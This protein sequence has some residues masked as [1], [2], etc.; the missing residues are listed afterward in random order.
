MA[1]SI[2]ALYLDVTLGQPQ[3]P[4]V[5]GFHPVLDPWQREGGRA[6][7]TWLVSELWR[8]LRSWEHLWAWPSLLMSP[9]VASPDSGALPASS[10]HFEQFETWKTNTVNTSVLGL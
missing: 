7:A 8:K 5:F 4:W 9:A 10:F 6:P 1:S 3:T 2:H